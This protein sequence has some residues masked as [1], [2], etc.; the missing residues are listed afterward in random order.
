MEL[1]T[2]NKMLILKSLN[3][4]KDHCI[5]MLSLIPRQRTVNEEQ[6]ELNEAMLRQELSEIEVLKEELMK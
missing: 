2:T 5:Y 6:A 1:S 3:L 4:H